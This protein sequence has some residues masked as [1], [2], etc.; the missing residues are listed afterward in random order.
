MIRRFFVGYFGQKPV[1]TITD[2]DRE[3]YVEWRRTYWT[4]GLGKE[5]I[6]IQYERGSPVAPTKHYGQVRLERVVD[7]LRPDWRRA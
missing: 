7:R 3:R 2:A 5:V 4:R 6:H 1:D